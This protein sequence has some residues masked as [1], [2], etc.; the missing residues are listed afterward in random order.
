MILVFKLIL[1]VLGVFFILMTLK[2]GKKYKTFI[3]TYKK[4]VGLPFMAPFAL[5]VI[6][7]FSIIEKF[8]KQ[9]VT[10]QQ[11]MI[12]LYGIKDATNQTKAFLVQLVSMTMLGFM[13]TLGVG[14]IQ[15]GDSSAIIAIGILALLIPVALI[16]N[17]DT[18]ERERRMALVYELPEFLNKLILLINAG[19]T[20]QK[21]FVR[22]TLAK[23]ETINKSPLYYELLEAVT[24]IEN[25]MPFSEALNQLSKKCALQEISIF[26]TTLLLNYRKGGEELVRS[27]KEMSTTLW[28]KRKAQTQ[29]RGEEASSKMV[30]PLIMIFGIVM[31][32]IGYPA[33]A[34]F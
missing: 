22:C 20:A 3:E 23:A 17:L 9:I 31:I 33:V 6:D 10:I 25:N 5:E 2:A 8:S 26:T 32:I 11:K 28:A 15:N 30:L 12:S 29:M 16:K 14:I 7:S 21:A 13:M 4:A 24:K 27:L 18:K 1:I 19:E 34:L